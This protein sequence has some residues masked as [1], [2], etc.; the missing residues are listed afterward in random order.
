MSELID[1]KLSKQIS[2]A[3]LSTETEYM[4]QAF[5]IINVMW[6][7]DI[8]NEMSIQKSMSGKN[9]TIIYANNQK[10]IK[11]INNSIFQKRTKHIVVNYHYTKDLINQK[12]IKLQYRLTA[13]IIANGL[14]KSLESVQFQRFMTQLRM[15]KKSWM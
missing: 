15:I 8:L 14:I 2:V 10:T 7:K 13:K 6:I 1:W 9:S 3:L 4:N 11:L 12:E 5:A